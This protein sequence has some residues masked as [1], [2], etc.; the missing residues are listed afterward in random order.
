MIFNKKK[1][2]WNDLNLSV[3]TRF[4]EETSTSTSGTSAQ[5]DHELL[6]DTSGSPT[7]NWELSAVYAQPPGGTLSITLP[8]SS[9]WL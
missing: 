6:N 1:L 5:T 8:S 3:V 2:L 9:L 7:P 4:S